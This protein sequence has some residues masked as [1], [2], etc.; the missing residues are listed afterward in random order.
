MSDPFSVSVSVLTVI[1]ACVS[2]SKALN[3]I[4]Q[5]YKDAPSEITALSKEVEDD[6][7]ILREIN[8][9]QL[10]PISGSSLNVII[11]RADGKL[12]EL[13]DFIA[14][15]GVLHTNG[16]P[17]RSF[18]KLKWTKSKEK[19]RELL[20]A[21]RD[22]K[23]NLGLL[24]NNSTLWVH[25]SISVFRPFVVIKNA[26]LLQSLK[27]RLRITFNIF[28][29][30]KKNSQ[31]IQTQSSVD[32]VSNDISSLSLTNKSQHDAIST[33]LDH[34]NRQLVEISRDLNDLVPVRDLYHRE[35]LNILR[36]QVQP[37][38]HNGA[39]IREFMNFMQASQPHGIGAA[40]ATYDQRSEP[41]SQSTPDIAVQLKKRK[42]KA[43]VCNPACPCRC[44]KQRRFRTPRF[45]DFFMGALSL[46]FSGLPLVSC[47]NSACWSRNSM[48]TSATYFFPRWFLNRA[49]FV[50]VA[51][52]MEPTVSLK[53]LRIVASKAWGYIGIHQSPEN[54]SQA[55]MD[56][57]RLFE[58]GLASP[59]DIDFDRKVS[60]LHVGNALDYQ[61][62]KVF[63]EL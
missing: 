28:R 22:V 30:L 51:N 11:S 27:N 55:I 61:C 4:I 3:T 44:H 21:L 23:I 10:S 12:A 49:L 7:L 19:S 35:V 25:R 58:E 46:G 39:L 2:I 60:L 33:H 57:K 59:N 56:T 47:D 34:Q 26:P 16:R 43:N 29:V 38:E 24:I 17:Q 52:S 31:G 36:Y 13:K 40:Q 8:N 53:V 42:V 50:A 63:D 41:E 9:Q 5:N 54:N 18:E 37:S 45:L 32:M 48:T 20:T 6:T 14:K 1:G 15:L 62:A